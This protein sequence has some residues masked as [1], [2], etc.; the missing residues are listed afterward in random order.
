MC[1]RDSP[2]GSHSTPGFT[3][4]AGSGGIQGYIGGDQTTGSFDARLASQGG[5]NAHNNM[6][7]YIVVY[8]WKRAS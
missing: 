7:P 4:D 1:I 5:G 2:R 6:P 3:D 8:M